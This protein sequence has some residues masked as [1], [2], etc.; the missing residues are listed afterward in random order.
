M[1]TLDIRKDIPSPVNKIIFGD[2]VVGGT[3]VA[4]K[5]TRFPGVHVAIGDCSRDKVLLHSKQHALD[6]IKAIQ[7][8][9]ELEW[10]K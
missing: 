1:S 8:A 2:E 6:A 7:K 4:H 9:I 3:H 5:L 10:L